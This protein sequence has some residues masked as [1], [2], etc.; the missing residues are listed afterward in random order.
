MP[1]DIERARSILF[2]VPAEVF[3]NFLA[4]LIVHD[5]GWPFH[6][7]DCNLDDSDWGRIFFPF[8]LRDISHLKWERRSLFLDQDP[9]HP[10]SRDDVGLVIHN[11]T[12][13]VWALLGRDSEPSRRWNGPR[14]K[15]CGVFLSLPSDRP[16]A[17]GLSRFPYGLGR[18][19]RSSRR[20]G[21]AFW[22]ARAVR[23]CLL[24]F[25]WRRAMRRRLISVR[26][27]QS[28]SSPSFR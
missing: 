26:I 22:V 8:S 12:Q 7:V 5:I 21:P 1:A 17:N 24:S 6:S 18:R 20:S 4:P 10:V 3:D 2:L 16:V 15:P 28:S 19:P 11:K 27:S 23:Y 14:S 25:P 9:L 13:D